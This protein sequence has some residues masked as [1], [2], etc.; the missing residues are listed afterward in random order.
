MDD[1]PTVEQNTVTR[2]VMF[3]PDESLAEVI[4][5]AFDLY[6]WKLLDALHLKQPTSYAEE[7]KIWDDVNHMVYRSEPLTVAYAGD[8]PQPPD[9]NPL[10]DL[11]KFVKELKELFDDKEKWTAQDGREKAEAAKESSRVAPAAPRS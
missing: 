11:L 1:S 8:A 10:K 3:K 5:T 4:K 9:D 2:V 7:T 6:R